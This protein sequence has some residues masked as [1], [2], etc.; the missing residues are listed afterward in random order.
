MTDGR[1]NV[2]K[3]RSFKL[4]A[5]N[6]RLTVDQV[7]QIRKLLKAG[8]TQVRVAEK[9]GIAQTNVSR[10]ARRQTWKAVGDR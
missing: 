6:S 2:T 10:I 3:K 8:E 5:G 1:Q 9:F 4:G 7:R